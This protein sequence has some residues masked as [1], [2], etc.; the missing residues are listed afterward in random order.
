[1]SRNALVP[2]TAGGKEPGS[3]ETTTTTMT[4]T[5]IPQADYAMMIVAASV[6]TL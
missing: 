3:N 4:M 6:I 2:R 5:M 1:M